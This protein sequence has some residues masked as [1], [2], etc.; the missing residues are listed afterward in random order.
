MI[1]MVAVCSIN[2]K[3]NSNNDIDNVRRCMLAR[4]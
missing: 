4:T 1:M 2:W 3:Y